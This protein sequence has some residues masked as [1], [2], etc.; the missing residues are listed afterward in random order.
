MCGFGWEF[1]LGEISLFV[2]YD[3]SWDLLLGLRFLFFWEFVADE[4]ELVPPGTCMHLGETKLAAP[5]GQV[6]ACPSK[7]DSSLCRTGV[8]GGF[9][10]LGV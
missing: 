9:V 8:F 10:E 2:R 6:G 3:T 5:C 4:T 7:E 1:C